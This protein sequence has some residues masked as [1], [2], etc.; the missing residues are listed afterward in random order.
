[1]MMMGATVALAHS[2]NRKALAL[3]YCGCQ[4]VTD[5]LTVNI[6]G[7]AVDAIYFSYF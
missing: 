1:M 6:E 4:L 2:P 3:L 7:A 5:R